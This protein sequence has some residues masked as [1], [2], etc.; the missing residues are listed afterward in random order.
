MTPSVNIQ[1][2]STSSESSSGLTFTVATQAYQFH[3]RTFVLDSDN[4]ISSKKFS[5]VTEEL[6]AAEV[7]RQSDEPEIAPDENIEKPER[8]DIE[9]KL[10]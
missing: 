8:A 9:K 1:R 3:F 2:P 5:N 6:K 7:E 4:E 10:E